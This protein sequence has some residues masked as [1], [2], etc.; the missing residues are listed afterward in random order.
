[1]RSVRESPFLAELQIVL[2]QINALC[3]VLCV[4]LRQSYFE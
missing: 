1:M 4:I 2:G 3:L